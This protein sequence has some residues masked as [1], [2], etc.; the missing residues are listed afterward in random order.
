MADLASIYN[1]VIDNYRDCD[2]ENFNTNDTW[3]NTLETKDRVYSV[4]QLKKA[5]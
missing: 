4:E 2:T 1:Q 3:K 5:F